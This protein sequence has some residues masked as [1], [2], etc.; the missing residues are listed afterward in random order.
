[1]PLGRRHLSLYGVIAAVLALAALVAAPGFAQDAGTPAPA[2]TPI[3]ASQPTGNEIHPAHIHRGNCAN[4]DPVPLYPLADIGTIPS[5]NGTPAAGGQTVG[6]PSAAPVF[7]SITTL[8]VPF[9]ELTGG[10]EFAINVHESPQNID[11]YIAC[12]ELGGTSYGQTLAF[13]LKEQNGSGYV[14]F[15]LMAPEG[16]T[17]TTVTVYLSRGLGGN[18]GGTPT[19]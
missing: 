16:D 4:L 3:E 19:P 12:G 7:Q 8:P 11:R 2:A 1:M 14:G 15:A 18:A 9:A 17:E 13:G 5:A 10:G 6:S